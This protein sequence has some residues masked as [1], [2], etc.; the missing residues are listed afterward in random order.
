MKNFSTPFI[1]ETKGYVAGF[2]ADHFS[3]SICYH[4]IDHTLD[5]VQAAEIIGEKCNLSERELE[6]VIVA[7]WFHDTGYYLGCEDHEI[8]SAEIARHYLREKNKEN[9]YIDIVTKCIL[10]TKVPQKPNTL[11]EKILCDADLYHLSS[12]QFFEKSELLWRE[13]SYKNENMTSQ[14]WLNQSKQFVENHRYH[15]KF[16]KEKLFPKLRKNLTLLKSKIKSN[17]H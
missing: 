12:E 9:E 1:D 16:G 5:V 14:N 7:A 10:S 17:T 11:L 13:F 3:E 15:T 6:M 4:N 8:T 2:I